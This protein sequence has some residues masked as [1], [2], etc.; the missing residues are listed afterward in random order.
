MADRELL[1]RV[2]GNGTDGAASILIY[3]AGS[4]F[5][6]VVTEEKGGDASVFL[7]RDRTLEVSNAL[8]AALQ[9]QR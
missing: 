4:Q 1:A 5:E 6:F 7:E 9:E 3:R 8:A 2:D